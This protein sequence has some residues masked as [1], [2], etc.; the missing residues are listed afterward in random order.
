MR[1]DWL[2]GYPAPLNEYCGCLTFVLGRSECEI[3]DG[4]GIDPAHVAVRTAAQAVDDFARLN[5]DPVT[6]AHVRLARVR[7]WTAAGEMNSMAGTLQGVARQLSTGTAAIAFDVTIKAFGSL[8]YFEDGELVTL[9]PID[10]Y[11]SPPIGREPYRFADVLRTAGLGDRGRGEPVPELDVW[12]QLAIAVPAI[13]SELGY[14]LP[15]QTWFGPLP[16]GWR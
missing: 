16:T 4:F 13:G 10:V 5:V 12:Q 2:I 6:G 3:F 11:P 1:W 7:D 15:E 14:D 9:L 8:S